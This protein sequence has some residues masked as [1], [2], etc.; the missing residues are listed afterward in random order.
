MNASLRSERGGV[1]VLAAVMIPVFLLLTALV[2]D[3]GDWYTHKRQLQNRADAAAFAAGVEYQK[4]WKACVQNGD[5]ALKLATAQKIA[6]AAR[7]YAG[8]PQ[9]SDYAPA[10]MPTPVNTE[11]AT[12]SK[13]DVVINSTSHTNDTDNSDGGGALNTVAGSPCY[14][15][16]ADDISAA[17]YWTDVKVKERDLPSLVGTIGLPL[18]QNLARARIEIRPATSGHRFLPLAVPDFEITRVQVRYFDECRDP[19]HTGAP[20]AIKD[21][22]PLPV[23]EQQDY[24]ASGG[25]T[26]WALPV[27]GSNPPVGDKSRSFGL[28][29]PVY[30]G[31]SGACGSQ[32]YLPVGVEVRIASQDDV[33]FNQSCDTLRNSIKFADCFSRMSQIRVYNDGNPDNQVRITNVRLS[34]GCPTPGDAYF[35]TLPYGLTTCRYDASAEVNWGNR[36]DDKLNVPANFHVTVNGVDMTPPSGSPTGVW[37]TSGGALQASPGANTVTVAV[38]WEDQ[39]SAHEYPVGSTNKCSDKNGNPCKYSDSQ[40]AH[41]AYVGD[42]VTG[43]AVELV[44]TSQSPLGVDGLPGP[45]LD[46]IA[47]GGA[48]GTPASPVQVFPTIGTRS[49]LKAGGLTTLRLDASQGNQTL[50]C[51]PA[52]PNGQEFTNFV[53]GCKPWYAKNQWS[54]PW[55]DSTTRTCPNAGLWFSATAMPPPYGLNSSTNPWQCVQLTGGKSKGQVGDWF[56]AATGNCDTIG[57]NKCQAIDCNVDGNYDGKTGK[58]NG[59]LQNGGDSRDPRV[60]GLFIVPYQALKGASGSSGSQVVP[61]L[62]FASF[63]VMNWTG[64]DKD[65]DKCPD[66]TLGTVDIPQPPPSSA[67]G[68]FVETVDFDAGPVDPTATCYEGLLTQCRAVLVR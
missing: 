1:M 39:N 38:S 41:Q 20:L 34:G 33:D 12:Q 30:Q 52:I 8:D 57:N 49:T 36:D 25:G 54:S 10:T 18:S 13:V 24:V 15:H 5:P 44:R 2:F 56:S 37:T 26:L 6:N 3:V 64:P 32:Q 17:G 16:A 7:Q 22:A 21:L 61:I 63:Y 40:A 60:V 67:S 14:A 31:G 62:G 68:V 53:T 59:W 50:Q 58:P 4:N 42:E 28:T 47:T 9:A 11:L 48:T 29:I 51:D 19:N 35:S 66:K 45:P 23:P 46:N 43:G 65:N 27:P 55:W